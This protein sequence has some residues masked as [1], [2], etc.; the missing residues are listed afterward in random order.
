MAF[1]WHERRIFWRGIG[2]PR[3]DIFEPSLQALAADP[4][5]PLLDVLLQQYDDVFAEPRGLP[6]SRPYNHRIHLL[7]GTAPVAVC[8]Y[9]YPQLQKDELERQC[10]TMLS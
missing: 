2:P 6:P 1:T 4:E 10:A 5:L 3:D 9:C 8:S 7:S